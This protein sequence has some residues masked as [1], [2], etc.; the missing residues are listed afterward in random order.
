MSVGA[1]VPVNDRAAR[2]LIGRQGELGVELVWERQN[3]ERKTAQIFSKDLEGTDVHGIGVGLATTALVSFSAPEAVYRA[4]IETGRYTIDITRTFG[5]IIKNLAT[6]HGSDVEL[7]GPVGI[8]VMTGDVARL[9]WVYLL[10]FTAVLSIN[11]AVLNILPIPALDGGRVL[12]LALEKILRRPVAMRVEAHAHYVG[13]FLLM[14]LV[15]L[16]TYRDI[17]R[18]FGA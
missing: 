17:A 6:G 8:A 7:S 2:A 4:T 16:V 9:G 15:I 12:F 11:L 13:F 5:L 1:E 3:G 18:I 14:L 10:Q